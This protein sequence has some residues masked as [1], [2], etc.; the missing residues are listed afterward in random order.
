MIVDGKIKLK[1][2]STLQRFT[3]NGLK[4]ED[5][6]KLDADVVVFAT[7]YVYRLRQFIISLMFPLRRYTNMRESIRKICG[8][9]ITN[10]LKELGGIDEEYE[11]NSVYRDCGVEN[12]WFATGT[13]CPNPGI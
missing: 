7:G 4:F 6:S 5:G 1:A 9:E 3:E 13:G 2:D 10:Q 8:D 12:L 11:L